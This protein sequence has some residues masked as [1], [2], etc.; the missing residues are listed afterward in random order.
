MNTPGAYLEEA[1]LTIG[2]RGKEHGSYHTTFDMVANMWTAYL[3]G[4]GVLTSAITPS[5]VAM[6]MI[7]LKIARA[8]NGRMSNPD[9]YV[10]MAGYA[11]LAGAIVGE[12]PVMQREV[13]PCDTE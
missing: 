5:E 3:R 4:V 7:M 6:M 2:A 1:M 8:G 12:S 11:A 9:H 10:D 13:P